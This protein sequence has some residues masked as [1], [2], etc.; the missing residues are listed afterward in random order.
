[1]LE[2]AEEQIIVSI[3]YEYTIECYYLLW[4]KKD[5]FVCYEAKN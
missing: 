1:L 2:F 5:C 3:C 4:E